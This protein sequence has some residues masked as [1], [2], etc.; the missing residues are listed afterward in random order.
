MSNIVPA[1][2]PARLITTPVTWAMSQGF[3][4]S[5]PS[6]LAV[7]FMSVAFLTIVLVVRAAVWGRT[8]EL[9]EAAYRVLDRI[10]RALLGR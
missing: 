5:V 7:T 9:R 10:L 2:S 6:W 1:D 8:V 4:S 3:V